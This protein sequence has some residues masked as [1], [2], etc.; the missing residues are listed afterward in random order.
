MTAPT[1]QALLDEAE[2]IARKML[3]KAGHVSSFVLAHTHDGEKRLTKYAPAST[4][5]QRRLF[6]LQIGNKMRE[7]DTA[8]YVVVNEAWVIEDSQSE[9][10]TKLP[11]ESS[12][13]IDTLV[14]EAH[15][16]TSQ[17]TRIFK[18]DRSGPKPTLARYHDAEDAASLP[19]GTWDGLL[20]EPGSTH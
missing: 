7:R 20:Q 9:T 4:G 17:L 18:I 12:D 1:L 5:V 11:S 14:L 15:N 6:A 13:R 8:A 3:A 16:I 10:L 19:G 2:T